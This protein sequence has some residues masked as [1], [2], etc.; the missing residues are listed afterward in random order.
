MFDI[1]SLLTRS[2]TLFAYN[3]L[4]VSLPIIPFWRSSNN[5]VSGLFPNSLWDRLILPMKRPKREAKE[6]DTKP[7]HHLNSPRH[8]SSTDFDTDHPS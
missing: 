7:F 5:S 8:S 1:M 4:A 3:V 2:S 6:V